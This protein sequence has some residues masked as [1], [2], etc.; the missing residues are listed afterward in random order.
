MG[1]W[2]CELGGDAQATARARGA[3]PKLLSFDLTI[4][5]TW[6]G[7]DLQ[8]R[9]RRVGPEPGTLAAGVVSIEQRPRTHLCPEMP[10]FLRTDG[11]LEFRI[12]FF[13]IGFGAR[14]T[15][16]LSLSLSLSLP[17]PLPPCPYLA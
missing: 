12:V 7:P 6:L 13:L 1:L 8:S 9:L 2:L 4:S 14:L 10:L 16:S 15:L 11:K 3:G 17:L 5:R